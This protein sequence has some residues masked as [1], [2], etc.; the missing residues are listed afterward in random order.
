MIGTGGQQNKENVQMNRK[1]KICFIPHSSPDYLGGVSTFF[2]NL[3]EAIKR[4][5][6]NAEI[7]WIYFGDSNKSYSQEGIKYIEVK[8]S[9]GGIFTSFIEKLRFVK[10]LKGNNYD[11]LNTGSGIWAQ[12][13]RKP[14]KQKLVHTFHGTIY[15]F[16]KNHLKEYNFFKRVLLLPYL[17]VPY[18][19]EFITKKADKIICVS[20]KVR[21]DVGNL[22]G[23]KD[24]LE[25]I[26]TGVDIKRFKPG[27]RLLARKVLGLKRDFIYGLYVGRGGY[28]T[29]GLDRTIKFSEEVYKKNKNYRLLVVGP[30]KEKAGDLLDKEFVIYSR[31]VSRGRIRDY[32]NSADIFFCFSRIEGGAPTLVV[33]EAMAS[34]CF[35][36][37]ARSAEQEIIIDGKNGL[38]IRDFGKKGA[39]R[40][41]KIFNSK[42]KRERIIKGSLTKIKDLSLEKW[43]KRYLDF[44]LY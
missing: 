3:I 37:C 1:I 33:S 5:K 6:I 16:Y 2:K 41:L 22:Y 17:V 23:E 15:N 42:R 38:V 44:I 30:D 34:G 40:V 36:V 18:F 19:G 12:F 43:G 28:W 13:Y 39:E 4:E 25:V 10:I 31:S 14:K 35:I 11:I 24:N 8:H 7:T 32:Y 21:K 29:K 26:R 9:K 27:N 20:E